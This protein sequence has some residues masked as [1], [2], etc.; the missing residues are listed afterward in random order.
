MANTNNSAVSPVSIEIERLANMDLTTLTKR[1]KNSVKDAVKQFLDILEGK[2]KI[3]LGHNVKMDTQHK[4]AMLDI[5]EEYDDS[6]T[7]DYVADLLDNR[8]GMEVFKRMFLFGNTRDIET[9]DIDDITD[10]DNEEYDIDKCIE[11]AEANMEYFRGVLEAVKTA[12]E[13]GCTKL[14]AID[15]NDWSDDCSDDDDDD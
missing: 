11:R 13:R 5:T 14:A 12:K 9:S 3:N 10:D 1:Q 6:D 2:A 4:I 15:F 8:S 7:D